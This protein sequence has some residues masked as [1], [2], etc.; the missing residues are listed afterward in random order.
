VWS[1]PLR[2]IEEKMDTLLFKPGDRGH[3]GFP[4]GEGGQIAIHPFGLGGNYHLGVPPPIFVLIFKTGSVSF[5]LL[6]S[7]CLLALFSL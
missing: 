2:L 6:L 3:S 4:L 7:V 1:R 5:C